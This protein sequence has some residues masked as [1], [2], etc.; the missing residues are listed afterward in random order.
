MQTHTHIPMFQSMY[1]REICKV[2]QAEWPVTK[3]TRTPPLLSCAH[4]TY[5]HTIPNTISFLHSGSMWYATHANSH[6]QYRYTHVRVCNT[7]SLSLTSTNAHIIMLK[8]TYH[9]VHYYMRK[10]AYVYQR[11]ACLLFHPDPKHKNK[12]KNVKT[13]PRTNVKWQH[14][15]TVTQTPKAKT[16]P[17]TT[18]IQ[19]Y[20]DKHIRTSLDGTKRQDHKNK[21][22]PGTQ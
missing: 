5:F 17:P 2:A 4:I 16:P 6:R 10:V 19:T 7:E 9:Y 1:A 11:D 13:Q 20:T 21:S 8:R 15:V 12:H 18:C 22:H 14:N 3:N